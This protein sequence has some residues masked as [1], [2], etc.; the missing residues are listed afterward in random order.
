MINSLLV[1]GLAVLDAG[2]ATVIRQAF[3]ALIENNYRLDWN[4][5][6]CIIRIRFTV[7]L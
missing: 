7:C 3:S 4:I 5:L 6:L 2:V 1:Q